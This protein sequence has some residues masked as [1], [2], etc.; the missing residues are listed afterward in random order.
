MLMG[1]ELPTMS[2]FIARLPHPEI[3]LAAYGG[4]VFPIALIVESPIIMLLA[5]STALCKD[6]ASFVLLRKFMLSASALLTLL[7]ILIAFTPIYDQVVRGIIGA[8]EEIIEPARIG[9]R[10]MTPWTW[11]IAY[12][13]FNQGVLIR[14]GH[15]K[16]V[17]LG[18]LVR[19]S[20]NILIL[21][22]GFSSKAFPGIVVATCAII[23]GVLSEAV[24]SGFIVQPVL[25]RDLVPSPAIEPPLS[26]G[27]FFAFYI[28]LAM[29]SLL[30]LIVNPIG[31]AAVSRMPQA[32]DSLA[33]WPVITGLIFFFR[34]LGVAYNEVVVALLDKPFAYANLKRF[35]VILSLATTAALFLVAATPLS[36][37]WFIGVSA[38]HPRIGAIAQRALWIA[39][40][41]PA[42]SVLQ[43]WFQGLILSGK[44]TRG[45]TES[46][47]IYLIAYIVILMIGIKYS[48][49]AGIY[50]ALLGM[51]VSVIIQTIS[52]WLRAQPVQKRF[53]ES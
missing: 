42:L 14:T 3:N 16:S 24:F 53:Q 47:A 27:N 28:P 15:S 39:L 25:R 51:M 23:S 38:L 36:E 8:P 4:V 19:L 20:A 7:H 50:I 5:A 11:S 30:T 21:V 49:F 2:A 35:A 45:I 33:V 12:R 41:L 22:V 26:W 6:W 40:P 13:R 52:L 17:G 18:T 1:I 44:R 31:S 34:S 32:L 29:T 46:V 9:M 10:I 48:G 43:S 37:L